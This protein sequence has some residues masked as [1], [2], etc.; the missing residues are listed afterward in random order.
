V[1]PTA[2]PA[3]ILAA[4]FRL[5]RLYHP[6]AHHQPGLEQLK[7]KLETLFARVTEAHRVLSNPA[8]RAAYDQA[9]AARA[10]PAGEARESSLDAV[11]T[12]DPEGIA[13]L[14]NRAEEALA[15]GQPAQ[16]LALAGEALRGAVGD[17]RRRG[18]LLRAQALLKDGGARKAAEEELKKSIEVDPG[19]AEAHFLLGT[20]YRDGG[21]S[22][23]AAACFRRAI[24]LRPRHTEALAALAALQSGEPREGVL[25]RLFR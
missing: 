3:E 18:S 20:I 14:L 13:Q 5:A 15:R 24:A 16:A 17:L 9:C 19:H 1:A 10:E 4:Y 11:A 21:A 25:K 6:D 2:R 22:A 12:S 8:L 7:S 23:L